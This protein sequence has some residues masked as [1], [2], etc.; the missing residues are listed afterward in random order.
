VVIRSLSKELVEDG[1][2]SVK[3]TTFLTPQQRPSPGS[4]L[5]LR[6]NERLFLRFVARPAL[7]TWLL[8]GPL[9]WSEG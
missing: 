7:V 8:S 5:L 6:A 4:G 3:H 2:L 1:L 9:I